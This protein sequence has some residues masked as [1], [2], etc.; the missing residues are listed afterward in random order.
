MSAL[1]QI[2]TSFTGAFGFALMFNVK[3]EHILCAS[4]N[5]MLTWAV[6]LASVY[7]LDD[8][9]LASVAA[10]VSASIYA[11]TA[12]RHR[13]APATQFM[14]IGLIPLIPGASLY[15]TLYHTF[16]SDV[17]MAREYGFNTLRYVFGIVI[18]ISLVWSVFHFFNMLL[19]KRR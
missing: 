11:Q 6:Y 8:I 9:L 12:A 2:I 7:M 15:Y 4:V 14:I 17:E 16:I 19:H 18:G 10:S 1:I 13:M 3:K 5:G